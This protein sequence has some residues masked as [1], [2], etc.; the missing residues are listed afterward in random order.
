MLALILLAAS[1]TGF[2]ADTG[3]DSYI[4]STGDG[5]LY[6]YNETTGSTTVIHDA[7]RQFGIREWGDSY[8]GYEAYESYE[9]YEGY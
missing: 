9:G 3:E 5:H 4:Y 2:N 8:E 1:A 7:E 6:Q